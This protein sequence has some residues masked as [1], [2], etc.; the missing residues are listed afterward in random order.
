MAYLG[1]AARPGKLVQ[2]STGGART[3][4]SCKPRQQVEMAG[5]KFHHLVFQCIVS[6]QSQSLRGKIEY[7]IQ[8]AIRR[9]THA[10]AFQDRKGV[11]EGKSVSVRVDHGG[12][13]IIKKKK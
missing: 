3:D 5:G 1:P 12:R 6:D 11:G 9:Q 10:K 13:R 8:I 7:R 4:P 2:A